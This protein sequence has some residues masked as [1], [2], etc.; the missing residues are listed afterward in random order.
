VPYLNKNM[1]MI[2][3]SRDPIQPLKFWWVVQKVGAEGWKQ[4]A[5]HI[6]EMTAY[7]KQQLD[8]AGYPCWLNDYSNT[9]F[10]KRPSAALAHKYQLAQ[11]EDDR[12]GG[13]LA[14]VVVM[15]HFT[16]E[17]IDAFVAAIVQS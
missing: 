14:H 9:V 15:Q 8:K 16:K 5:S 17:K 6:M 2:N 10:M 13:Q 3:C 1:R 12:F 4:Q 7:L 11:N